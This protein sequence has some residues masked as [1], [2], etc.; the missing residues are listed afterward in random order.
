[1]HFRATATLS[2]LL[3]A[4]A[5]LPLNGQVTDARYAHLARGINL[6][7]WFL[8]GSPQPIAAADRDLLQHAG[9]TSVRIAVAP[10]Y[11]LPKWASPEKI[12]RTLSDLD[13]GI[14]LFLDSGMAVMLD[15]QADD[16][17]RDY[18]LSTPA[19]P[20]ELSETW[21]MLAARYA[22]RN[23]DLLF[24]EIMNEPD[25]R[26]TAAAWDAEQT[27]V[28]AAIR[29]VAPAHT[30]LLSPVNWSGLDALLETTPLPDP[31]VIYVLHYYLPMTFT[32]QGAT[33]TSS[34]AI[35]ALK[36]IPWPAFL[37]DPQA[38]GLVRDYRDDDRDA[39]SIDWD[40]SLAAAWSMRWNVRV[41][42]NEFGAY[43]PFAPPD[44]R[45]R[46]LADVRTALNRHRLAWSMWDYGA[47]FDLVT[48]QGTS[49]AI[50]PDIAV[51]LGLT[52]VGFTPSRAPE[53]LRRNL[54]PSYSNA[55]IVQLGR[56]PG[57]SGYTNA[58]ATADMNGDGLPDVVLT[59]WN[60]SPDTNTSIEIFLNKGGIF[61]PASFDGAAPNQRHVSQI[62]TGRFDRS[63][64]PGFFFPSSDT[65]AKLALPSAGTLRDASANIPQVAGL[66]GAA[67]FDADGDGVDDLVVFSPTPQLWRND[68]SGRFRIDARAFPATASAATCGIFVEN[69]LAVFG[70][71]EA[72]L[73]TNDGHG[74]FKPG[75][76]LPIPP[77]SGGPAVGGCAVAYDGKIIAAF[78][79]D[80]LEVLDLT[81]LSAVR[82]IRLPPSKNGVQRIA[83]AAG[84]VLITRPG[85]SPLLRSTGHPE[86][87]DEIE[88][89]LTPT[90][91][92]GIP[93]DIDGDGKSDILFGQAATQPLVAR[94]AR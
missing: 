50:D 43:K 26:F 48:G 88:R 72:R 35:A 15:F 17:Y 49:R 70:P 1:M 65:P 64:R 77:D 29:A 13:R 47:G 55:R 23:P 3:C 84:V 4:A 31:N 36:N 10:Q 38:D 56:A 69:R 41:V 33:W 68:G 89:H 85:D 18:Y 7:R 75:A 86:I 80:E 40:M 93:I 78:E 82:F 24:F 66:T 94:M 74:R 8:Y 39:S 71:A 20:A 52:G 76:V 59:R 34:S 62:V 54:A 9:F 63:G 44:A 60:D 58:L 67:A 73:Y 81:N 11:L 83:Q 46:W 45:A 61:E 92:I 79:H 27:R 5:F 19:A 16:E 51:A 57:N 32:H 30:V 42:V 21:R 14:D 91:S 37:A 12:A 90:L 87:P 25:A 22:S 28:L 2:L 6:T 53:I